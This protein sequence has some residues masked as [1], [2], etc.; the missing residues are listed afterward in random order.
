MLHEQ[1]DTTIYGKSARQGKSAVLTRTLAEK[2]SYRLTYRE[3]KRMINEVK[4]QQINKKREKQEKGK[5]AKEKEGTTR[6]FPYTDWRL[7]EN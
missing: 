3:R 4:V 1:Q 2:A 6:Y 7:I 5:V